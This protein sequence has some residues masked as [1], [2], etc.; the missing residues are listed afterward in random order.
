L[1]SNCDERFRLRMEVA[2]EEVGLKA[3]L[4]GCLPEERPLTEAAEA[5]VGAEVVD[6]DVVAVMG[7]GGERNV[8]CVQQ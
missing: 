3:G 8:C 6:V 7:G 5:A 4:A 1:L 2:D